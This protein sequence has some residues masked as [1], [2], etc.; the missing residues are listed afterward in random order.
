MTAP[1]PNKAPQ[2]T[3]VVERGNPLSVARSTSIDVIRFAVKPCPSD[4]VVILWAS[5]SP[6]YF[7]FK[8]PPRQIPEATAMMAIPFGKAA[9]IK[10]IAAIFGVSLSPLVNETSPLLRK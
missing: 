1:I 8:K 7:D 3:W 2:E 4:S 5:V 9:P 6:T 10:R